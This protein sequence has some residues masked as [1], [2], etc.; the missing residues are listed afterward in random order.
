MRFRRVGLWRSLWRSLCLRSLWRSLWRSLCLCSLWRSLGRSLCLRS[1]WRSLCLRSL[2]LFVGFGLD[3]GIAMITTVT[4]LRIATFLTF[5]VVA[6]MTVMSD[7]GMASAVVGWRSAHI[8]WSLHYDNLEATIHIEGR[9]CISN[10]LLTIFV[11]I[12]IGKSNSSLRSIVTL[13]FVPFEMFFVWCHNAI[14]VC[15]FPISI[16]SFL[17]AISKIEF[18]LWLV[19]I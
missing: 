13:F 7:V 10:M 3:F 2:G 4:N 8:G 1:L 6:T 14:A 16:S 18:N 11:D 9:N 19:G 17:R 15:I 12:R 5:T